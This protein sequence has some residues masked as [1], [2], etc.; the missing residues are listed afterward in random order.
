M[1][2]L[3]ICDGSS[4]IILGLKHIQRVR[5]RERAASNHVRRSCKPQRN[6]KNKNPDL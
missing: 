1:K 3:D 5:V 4:V 2:A 6:V